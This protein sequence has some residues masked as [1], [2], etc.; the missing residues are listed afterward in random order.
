MNM[1]IVLLI[2]KIIGIILLVL[3][4]ILLTLLLL[5]LFFPISYRVSASYNEAVKARA[6]VYWLFHLISVT[7]DYGDG[8]KKCILR[9]F[10]I[11]LMDFLNP[12]PKKK[13]KKWVP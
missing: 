12:K 2:L 11:P 8:V 9:L 13:K 7:F 5:V 4:G 1:E 10:G 6:K 3:L